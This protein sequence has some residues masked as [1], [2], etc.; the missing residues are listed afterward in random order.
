MMPAKNSSLSLLSFLF[1]LIIFFLFSHRHV[2]TSTH[3]VITIDIGLFVRLLLFFFSN[4]IFI[5]LSYFYSR[6]ADFSSFSL[7]RR[8]RTTN[9]TTTKTNKN[10]K[11]SIF[12]T[13]IYK[14]SLYM[15]NCRAFVVWGFWYPWCF[16]FFFLLLTSHFTIIMLGR[17]VYI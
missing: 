11:N 4:K 13:I 8:L 14:I 16:V 10:R 6:T 12:N 3:I 9:Y 5:S 1:L 15:L 17:Y 2:S 7:L